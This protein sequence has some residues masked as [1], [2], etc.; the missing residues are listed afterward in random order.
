MVLLVAHDWKLK[1]ELVNCLRPVVSM[2]LA[3]TLVRSICSF[4]GDLETNVEQATFQLNS[5]NHW[6]NPP[7]VRISDMQTNSWDMCLWNNHR[8]SPNVKRLE[9]NVFEISASINQKI[10]SRL[11][12]SNI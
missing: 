3:N 4:E 2:Q 7:I 1:C 11:V 5:T 9:A 12:E 6:E 10:S 8:F